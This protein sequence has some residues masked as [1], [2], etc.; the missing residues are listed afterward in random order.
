MIGPA[1]FF[2]HGKPKH[3][4]AGC[5][6]SWTKVPWILRIPF[7]SARVPRESRAAIVVQSSSKRRRKIVAILRI[8]NETR[9]SVPNPKFVS[10]R[11][12]LLRELW[13]WFASS[14]DGL[15]AT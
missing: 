7:R 13:C 5:D 8:C 1:R 12:G 9:H 2:R 11:S 15:A 4:C 10:L 6:L 3:F 14:L